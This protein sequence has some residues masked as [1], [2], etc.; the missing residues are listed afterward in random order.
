MMDWSSETTFA[1]CYFCD[2]LLQSDS[3]ARTLVYALVG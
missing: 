1:Q 3:G 2:F